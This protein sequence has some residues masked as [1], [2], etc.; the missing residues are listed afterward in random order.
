MRLAAF[1]L[2]FASTIFAQDT[3]APNGPILL[4]FVAPAY[5][6]AAQAG[7]IQG[8]AIADITIGQD[9]QVIDV[10]TVSAHPVFAGYV[11]SALKQWRFK[12]LPNE[13]TLRVTTRFEFDDDCSQDTGKRSTI[14][15]THVSADL[16]SFIHVTTGLP[17]IETSVN[18]TFHKTKPTQ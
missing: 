8:T 12:H 7:R 17:C 10:K 2:V 9:G 16:P 6:R 1:V 3:P 4:T 5:P 14:S 15:E 13:S 18:Q 11:V